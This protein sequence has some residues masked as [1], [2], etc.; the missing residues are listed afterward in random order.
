VT[1]LA[2]VPPRDWRRMPWRNGGGTTA[3][4]LFE[5]GREGRFLWRLSIAD[6]AASGPFSD[7]AGYDR[8]ILLLEGRGFVLRFAE[9]PEHRL[10]RRL[11]P[12]AFDGGWRAG[13]ELVDGPVRDLNLMVSRDQ[14]RGGLRAL[15]LAAWERTEIPLAGTVLLHLVE[16]S[17]DAGGL[18][19]APGDTLRADGGDGERLAVVAGAESRVV[20]ATVTPS[21]P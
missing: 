10:D 5:P 8:H 3:E 4:I 16:G 2:L 15:R 21:G 9:A 7:F 20:V 13:C 18:P 19:L 14:A 12:F 11:E 17:L 6:V 1:R